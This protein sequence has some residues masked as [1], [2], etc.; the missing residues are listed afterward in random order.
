MTTISYLHKAPWFFPTR[1]LLSFIYALVSGLR[2]KLYDTGLLKTQS[3]ETFVLS[4][5]NLSVGGSGKTILVQALLK[6]FINH[7]INPAVL[8]RGY[9]RSSRGVFLVADKNTLLGN[10]A[11]SGDEPYLIAQNYPGVPVVVAENRFSGAQ[12][13]QE[14]FHPDVIILDD[15]FQHRRLHRDLDLLILDQNRSADN[16][17]LLPWGRL[18][19]SHKNQARAD[20]ILFSKGA[21]NGKPDHD[22]IFEL[23][24][25][26]L[27]AFGKKHS[28]DSLQGTC[29]LFAGLG[30]TEHFFTSVTSLVGASKM[31]LS[32]PDHAAYSL[33]DLNRIK[34][35]NCEQ[36]ITTQKDFI[37][38]DPD[39]CKQHKIYYIKVQTALPAAL[40]DTLKQHFK[41]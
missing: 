6:Y 17:H 30:N 12:L 39:F 22:L 7:N 35:G 38:L 8:S 28:L 31:Q 20:V 25:Y 23:F 9:K 16:R 11:N 10:P 2:N 26:V 41:Q 13:L 14:T 34:D 15:G 1:I 29:G 33:R 36:W 40:L 32:F 4:V 27:D 24:D 18:R 21:S 19:E 3:V 37:K 5:G